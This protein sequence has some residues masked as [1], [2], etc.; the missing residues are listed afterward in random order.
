MIY[1]N[2]PDYRKVFVSVQFDCSWIDLT[3]CCCIRENH[4]L[5]FDGV[6]D[7]VLLPTVK[8]LR[9]NDRQVIR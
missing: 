7:S 8:E 3:F 4:A 5:L 9:L 2:V 1:V 6:R